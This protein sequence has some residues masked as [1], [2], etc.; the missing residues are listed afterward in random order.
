MGEEEGLGHGESV[1][2]DQ[3][4]A[5]KVG[6]H[7]TNGDGAEGRISDGD[8]ILRELF[9]KWI[10]QRRGKVGPKVFWERSVGEELGELT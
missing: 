3:D 4:A 6:Y 5:A 8:P 7:R 9:V 2:P 1:Q 10:H